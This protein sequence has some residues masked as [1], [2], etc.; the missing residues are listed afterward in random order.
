MV[1]CTVQVK[2]FEAEAHFLSKRYLSKEHISYAEFRFTRIKILFCY[3]RFEKNQIFLEGLCHIGAL[4]TKTL[5][6][7]GHP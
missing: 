1:L 7:V 6:L 3:K 2:F 5:T 4:C